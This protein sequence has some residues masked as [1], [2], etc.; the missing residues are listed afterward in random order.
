[1]DDEPHA[2]RRGWLKNN[3]PPGDYFKAQRCGARTRQQ[4]PCQCPAMRNGRCRMHGGLSRGPRTPGGL[5]RSQ[6]ARWTHGGRS[7][8]VRMM[9]AECRRQ[10]R[11][12]RALLGGVAV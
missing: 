7:L 11:E 10:W 6:K 1:M 8:E 2:Q 12:L 5:E 9:R 4:K 3:N